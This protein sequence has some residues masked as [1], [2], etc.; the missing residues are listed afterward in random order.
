M[1]AWP[2]AVTPREMADGPQEMRQINE[3]CRQKAEDDLPAGESGVRAGENLGLPGGGTKVMTVD[4]VEL[5]AG[6]RVS[7]HRERRRGRR[8]R[9]EGL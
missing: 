8:V 3:R 2:A 5:P 7:E 1:A 6:M 9:G 4:D